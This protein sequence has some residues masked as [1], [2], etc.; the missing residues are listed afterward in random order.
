MNAF[1]KRPNRLLKFFFKV[2]IWLHKTGLDGW[3]SLIGARA[4]WYKNIQSSLVFEAQVGRSKFKAR[5]GALSTEGSG[6][7]LVQF[8]RKKPAYTRSMMA[9]VGMKFKDGD[10]L[11]SIAKKFNASCCQTR[12]RVLFTCRQ[13]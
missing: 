7:M 6:E 5:A 8:Y 9:M 3:Q 4:D 1:D 2:S 10:E 11:R 13:Y 12:K